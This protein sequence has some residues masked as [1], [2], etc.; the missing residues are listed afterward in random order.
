MKQ[1]INIGLCGLGTVGAGVL[2]LLNE[3]M[4]LIRDRVGTEIKITRAVT[5]DPY[6]HLKDELSEIIV[7]NSV[8]DI[9]ADSDIDIVVEMIGG[10][11]IAKNV[12]LTALEKN[13]SVVTANKALL[14][15]YSSQIFE[16][17]YQ[18]DSF[19]GFEA[20]VG[21]GIP[22]IRTIREGFSGDRI[23]EISGIVNGTANYILSSMT[24]DNV[25]FKSALKE[26]QEKG[27]AEADPSFDIE[28]ID[29]AHKVLILMELAFGS[30]FDFEQLYVEG[31]TEVEPID[32]EI[33]N[34][35]QYVIKLVGKAR[36]TDKGYEG[37]V[38]PA[39]VPVYAM[40]ASVQGAFNAISVRG[41][42]VGDTMS[43]GAGAG[44]FP[45]ASAVV[46]D[47]I[48]ISRS[49]LNKE[50]K[51]VPPLS[52]SLENLSKKE[53]LPIDEIE[54]EYYLRFDVK[55]ARDSVKEIK[56][57]LV[58]NDV[59]IRFAD[60]KWLNRQNDGAEQV[61]IF[62]HKTAEKRIQKS[63]HQINDLGGGTQPGKL[64]R[65]ET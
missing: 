36:Q 57:L 62:T 20:S 11:S 61:V 65:I 51:P 45:T 8:E 58:E 53:I 47:I 13:K 46:A 32:I 35:Y 29:A 27:F 50:S 54:S 9:L 56:D 60:Q 43:Y 31:I 18:S 24:N 38:H 25:D 19:I 55:N 37:R 5:V 63:L 23:E 41:N 22:I 17:A 15:E 26:A 1:S 42:F 16:A 39:L 14:A 48:Q 49:L 28:G 12:I 6:D 21:G 44:S 52:V 3:N 59:S 40:L 64:I 33:A 7:T 4:S 10:L 2:K 34:E 30:L